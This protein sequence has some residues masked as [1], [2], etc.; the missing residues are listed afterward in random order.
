MRFNDLLHLAATLA[1]RLDRGDSRGRRMGHLRHLVLVAV[2]K[3]P[4]SP[5]LSKSSDHFSPYIPLSG[6]PP[7]LAPWAYFP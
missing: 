7:P 2:T 1:P 5:A 3:M 6:V 4:E